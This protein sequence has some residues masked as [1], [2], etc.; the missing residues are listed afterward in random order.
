MINN[1]DQNDAK[2]LNFVSSYKLSIVIYEFSASCNLFTLSNPCLLFSHGAMM[3]F[4]TSYVHF[5][6]NP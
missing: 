5:L 1:Q 2:S 4:P 6:I 3:I